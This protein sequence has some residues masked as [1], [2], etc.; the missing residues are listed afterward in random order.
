MNAPAGAA[1]FAAPAFNFGA[2]AFE[3][4]VVLA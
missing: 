1:N 4:S 3:D 2:F